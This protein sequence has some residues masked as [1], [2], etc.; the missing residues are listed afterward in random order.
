MLISSLPATHQA[1][2]L[3]Y[4]K[5]K[6]VRQANDQINTLAID[7]Q[8]RVL[9][10]VSLTEEDWQNI[11]NMLLPKIAEDQ[12][13]SLVD[14]KTTVSLDI[15][16]QE[17]LQTLQQKFDTQLLDALKKVDAN[18]QAI[19][20]ALKKTPKGSIIALQQEFHF[21]LSL[22]TRVY[23]KAVDD[24]DNKGE[25]LQRAHSAA[26]L[27]V[28]AL[29]MEAY[30]AALKK[31]YKNNKIDLNVLNHEL[32]LARKAI[33]PAAH[34]ILR[35]EILRS[36]G[37]L[38]TEESF[39]QPLKEL[40]EET[41]ATANDLLHT[42]RA[43]GLATWIEGSEV[44]AHDRGW[45]KNH[46]ATRTMITHQYNESG[47]ILAHTHPRT[48]I[49]VTSLDAKLEGES[50]KNHIYDVR[51]KLQNIATEYQLGAGAV[52]PPQPAFV[53]NLYTSLYHRLDDA[54]GRNKQTQ[55]ARQIIEGAHRYNANALNK[56]PSVLCFVQ[57][58]PI[59]GFG[60]A[61]GY[62]KFQKPL[63]KE[64]TLMSEI[65]LLHTL[66]AAS[67]PQQKKTIDDV[68]NLYKRYV[69]NSEGRFFAASAEGRKAIEKIEQIK[70]EWKQVPT[71]ATEGDLVA[72]A[73]V[74]L[75]NL[76]AHNLHLDKDYAK[77]VQS[78]S[79][80][81]EK[82]S[83]GG[84][85]SA[86]ERAQ[87]I[88]GRVAVLDTLLLKKSV[89]SLTEEER[90]L[91]T[92]LKMCAS[93][94]RIT[95]RIAK[96]L[97]ARLDQAF[98]QSGL[99]R[100][101]TLISLVDQG[102]SAKAQVR[103]PIE[104][105]FNSNQFEE[106]TLS[107]L[108]QSKASAM[109]AH[110]ELGDAMMAACSVDA[111]AAEK[112]A[113][114]APK[115]KNS[116]I[117]KDKPY[118]EA[119]E[120]GLFEQVGCY[121]QEP[122]L[123]HQFVS[124]R[125]GSDPL[126]K[127]YDGID[128]YKKRHLDKIN[129]Y[130][131]AQGL[132]PVTEDNPNY[133]RERFIHYCLSKELDSFTIPDSGDPRKD[134]PEKATIKLNELLGKEGAELYQKALKEERNSQEYMDAVLRASTTHYMGDKWAQRPVV[135]VGGPSAS[136]KSVAA[137]QAIEKAAAFLQKVDTGMDAP[138]G[139]DVVAVD[140][141]ICREVS[142]IRKLA[143]RVANQ[144][145]FPAI[146]DLHAKSSMLDKAKGC[147]REAAFASTLGVVIPDT[148]SNPV[149][150]PSRI[151]SNIEKLPN[152]KLIF[153]RVEADKKVVRFMGSRR[154]CK[155]KNFDRCPRLDLNSTE[156]LSESKAYG[157]DGFYWGNK[158][159]REAE[160][161]YRQSSRDKISFLI[162]NDLI[163][164]KPVPK[165]V[166]ESNA[167]AHQW[168]DA[169][170]GDEGTIIVSRRTF[171]RWVESPDNI[172]LAEFIEKTPKSLLITTFA[173]Q[174]LLEA[175]K[176]L[177]S[178]LENEIKN[179]N[180]GP[181]IS[182]LELA[183]EA[184]KHVDPTSP[185]SF[186]EAIKIIE[187]EG[188][189]KRK[190]VVSSIHRTKGIL[191]NAVNALEQRYE[192]L[193]YLEAISNKKVAPE[194]LAVHEKQAW[195]QKKEQQVKVLHELAAELDSLKSIRAQVR[196]FSN[197][198][199]I[200]LNGAFGAS[201]QSSAKALNQ[202]VHDLDENCAK[203]IVYL[204]GKKRDIEEFLSELP[205]KP[206]SPS[207]AQHRQKLL[208][209]LSQIDDELANSLLPTQKILRGDPDKNHSIAQDGLINTVETAM[210]GKHGIQVFSSFTS[211]IG[212]EVPLAQKDTLFSIPLSEEDTTTKA[213]VKIGNEK[214]PTY[215]MVERVTEG[216]CRPHTIKNQYG[217]EI[218]SFLEERSKKTSPKGHK[219]EGEGIEL[220]AIHFPGGD[221]KTDK[222][223]RDNKI[224]YSFAMAI[225]LLA[226][227][228]KAPT[229]E[230][231]LVLEGKDRE[232]IR[233]VFTAL[234]V[235]GDESPMKFDAE[236]ISTDPTFFNPKEELGYFGR[237]SRNSC[238]NT[239]FKE[240]NVLTRLLKDLKDL[241]TD[242][243]GHT[244]DQQILEKALDQM[245]KVYKDKIQT[246]SG[247]EEPQEE[248][249]DYSI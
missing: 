222:N 116:K 176:Q 188:K 131:K 93:N 117:L 84:C 181:K 110:K 169:N 96:Q 202:K 14:R 102:A 244:K 174:N 157:K 149:K 231:P 237:F 249:N 95:P 137:Q 112:K 55:G 224:I 78:L 72:D 48:Q 66:Y 21:H 123:N 243:M 34:K 208:R 45:G 1:I 199:F 82:A 197:N 40:A 32:D 76:V 214:G 219:T 62:G 193:I 242:K 54:Q 194:A 80:F 2:Y 186:Q 192:E 151:L 156:D 124:D 13:R 91:K 37:V 127:L 234:M 52:A 221:A 24:F 63:V 185:Q 155:T 144:Q 184:I 226:S 201:A 23:E 215:Q 248:S 60:S 240:S 189:I 107:N 115:G 178:R 128:K 30:A 59:N 159:S 98:N 217:V 145:G 5:D 42:D 210:L 4:L 111:V 113:D 18:F 61:L 166:Q 71:V 163:L 182:V 168:A 246:M 129:E 87:S 167:K 175:Q 138:P 206:S 85:K 38:L 170:Q 180:R 135:I 220:T 8:G 16:E 81:L 53:Y 64:A 147:I 218:G 49:R 29:V 25:Q 104:G 152:T 70:N 126:K 232:A 204:Q 235:L 227:M 26:M 158:G 68:I 74:S 142:Q 79:V 6:A 241:T 11:N 51:N 108:H 7:P 47:H 161:W 10:D 100:A 212:A 86:N 205:E 36:T 203:L 90:H 99:Q 114:K 31:A 73:T 245:T 238:Y 88:N 58:I 198:N 183:I 165:D 101:A 160:Q 150:S 118:D 213:G 195:M 83:I 121:K 187:A 154:A 17:E 44:T 216:T 191:I 94:N 75:K 200:W 3:K 130:N 22:A 141:G 92:A 19:P 39:N 229:K 50:E 207:V 120:K 105:I 109:Q 162:I 89:F 143:I 77:L 233:F 225:Q 146:S 15:N 153:T 209:A 12:W 9:I 173:E 148:F 106:P 27:Q 228:E 46:T 56:D 125:L 20:K 67:T 247:G 164:K 179:E 28:N 177:E 139:N 41:T 65:A 140:G 134:N 196:S 190:E 172:T 132:D 69:Q 211:E 35:N 43:S 236:A 133:F 171:E 223:A 119:Q 33:T 57:N 230:N 97:K 136:G 103:T 239:C 122:A